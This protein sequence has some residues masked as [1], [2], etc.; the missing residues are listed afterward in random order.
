MH[1]GGGVTNQ[2]CSISCV[3]QFLVDLLPTREEKKP[4]Q[5]RRWKETH[6]YFRFLCAECKSRANNWKSA[7]LEMS[8][9]YHSASCRAMLLFIPLLVTGVGLGGF[10]GSAVERREGLYRRRGF[11]CKWQS[12][13]QGHLHTKRT[14]TSF[15]LQARTCPEAF[16]RISDPIASDR[17]QFTASECKQRIST[18]MWARCM[19]ACDNPGWVRENKE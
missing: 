5:L 12:F 7:C 17:K 15:S 16:E 3:S 8:P 19:K 1:F 2:K 4:P 10:G 6:Y 9:Q 13:I 18:S 14:R 11:K